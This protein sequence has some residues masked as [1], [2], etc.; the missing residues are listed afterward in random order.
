MTIYDSM[1][2]V[3]GDCS[4]IPSLR[5]AALFQ[6]DQ[7]SK[8]SVGTTSSRIHEQPVSFRNLV[9]KDLLTGSFSF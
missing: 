9:S 1:Y 6:E 5:A 3:S 8:Q 2:M 4:L 7:L